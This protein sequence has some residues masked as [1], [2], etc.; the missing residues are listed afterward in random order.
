MTTNSLDYH[1][2]G[3][4]DFPYVRKF[5][6]RHHD[7]VYRLRNMCVTNDLKCHEYVPVAVI[8]IRSFPN[9]SL[10]TSLVTRITRWVPLVEKEL[11][12]LPEH[13]S[14]PLGFSAVSVAQYLVLCIMLCLSFDHCIVCPTSWITAN[15]P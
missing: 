2:Y 6:S 9:L 5:Y 1:C 11:L 13:M 7:L 15:S 4:T 12:V 3:I 10:I 14:S 8:T